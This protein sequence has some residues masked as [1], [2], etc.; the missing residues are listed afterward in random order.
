VSGSFAKNAELSEQSGGASGEVH[1][2]QPLI[3]LVPTRE[4]LPT[5]QRDRRS[6]LRDASRTC[7]SA[8]VETPADTTGSRRGCRG[9][10]HLPI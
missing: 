6:A 5:L 1:G 9:A 7:A 10:S 3:E 4:N 8:Y 2:S